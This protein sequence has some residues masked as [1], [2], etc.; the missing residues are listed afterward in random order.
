M[1]AGLYFVDF[2]SA[3][4]GVPGHRPTFGSV[5]VQTM[6]AV[7]QK[8]N[9]IE[10]SLGDIVTQTC[11]RSLFP[12]MGYIPCWYLS[13]HKTRQINIGWIGPGVDGAAFATAPEC[14]LRYWT[15][16]EAPVVGLFT[17]LTDAVTG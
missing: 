4:Y 14:G 2:L 17:P 12:Q 13:G 5:Q 9:R 10:Y 16:R 7:R 1:L 6:Y 3:R 15:A 11:V 8:N